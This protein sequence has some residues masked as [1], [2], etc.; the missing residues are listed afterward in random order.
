MSPSQK[1]IY[2]VLK[3]KPGAICSYSEL[4]QGFDDLKKEEQRRKISTLHV[5]INAIKKLVEREGNDKL[6]NHHGVGYS[7]TLTQSLKDEIATYPLT[8]SEAF[9]SK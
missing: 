4:I 8:P 7:L 2:D 6:K 3:N 5:H 1:A 9:T